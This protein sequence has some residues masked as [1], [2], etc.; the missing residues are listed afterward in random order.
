MSEIELTH[1]F[2]VY[3]VFVNFIGLILMR[4]DKKRAIKG[5]WR[6]SE[7]FLLLISLI[8]GAFGMLVASK[9]YRHKTKKKLFSIG[10]PFLLSVHLLLL[11]ILL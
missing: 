3:L 8:G 10:L 6:I 5:T 4:M 1:I 11:I 2:V 7:R 9:V